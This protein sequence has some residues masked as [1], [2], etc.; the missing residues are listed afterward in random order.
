MTPRSIIA[1][2]YVV[3]AACVAVINGPGAGALA[4]EIAVFAVFELP[5]PELVEDVVRVAWELDDLP[6][7]LTEEPPENLGDVASV[8]ADLAPGAALK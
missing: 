5:Q 6:A 3:A 7:Y 1:M 8:S 2:A 4:G